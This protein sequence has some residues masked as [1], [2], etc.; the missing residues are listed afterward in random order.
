MLLPDT[1]LRLRGH[2][3]QSMVYV[4][5]IGSSNLGQ[6]KQVLAKKHSMLSLG[7]LG[8]LETAAAVC[9]CLLQED[10][11]SALK[12]QSDVASTVQHCCMLAYL[13]ISLR[14]MAW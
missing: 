12:L 1:A 14:R 11:S 8:E 3:L 10:L 6:V 4:I 7:G 9:S 2:V 13:V 5:I